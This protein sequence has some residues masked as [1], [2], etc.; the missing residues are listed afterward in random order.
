MLHKLLTAIKCKKLFALLLRS[1]C[2][3]VIFFFSVSAQ[4][5]I[6]VFM[7]D[8]NKFKDCNNERFIFWLKIKTKELVCS[9]MEIVKVRNEAMLLV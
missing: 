5:K 4:V 8:R 1:V 6:L 2:V 3:S 9:T 7:V